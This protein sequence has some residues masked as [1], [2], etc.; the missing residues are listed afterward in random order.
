ML[1]IIMTLLWE[2]LLKLQSKEDFVYDLVYK[3]SYRVSLTTK[4]K[5]KPSLGRLL[6]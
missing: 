2:Y 4:P 1:V 5:I 6:E 3:I